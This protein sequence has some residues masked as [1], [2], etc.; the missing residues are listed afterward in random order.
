MS[1]STEHPKASEQQPPPP[2]I[3][4]CQ[5]PPAPPPSPIL[6]LNSC[7]RLY[8]HSD[9]PSAPS[10]CLHGETTHPCKLSHRKISIPHK[11]MR[12]NL[13]TLDK[14]LVILHLAH[15]TTFLS[16]FLYAHIINF[17]VMH[18]YWKVCST[19]MLYSWH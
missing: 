15:K 17:F 14:I 6:F 10:T 2:I 18:D 12:F 5:K 1:P 7:I 16:Q 4:S 19:C 13:Y 11:R 3:Y 8:H 9:N